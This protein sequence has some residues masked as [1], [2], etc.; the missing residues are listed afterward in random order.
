MSVAPYA[1]AA[2]KNETLY[3]VA[4]G[5]HTEIGLSRAAAR[6]LPPALAE[7][8][9]DARYLVFG[10]GARGYYTAGH[11]D[12]GDA[13]RAMAPGPAVLLVIPLAVPPA[14]E[15][16]ADSVLALPVSREGIAR[17]SE[18]LWDD[19]AKDS[20]GAPRRL[21]AGPK[22][23]SAFYASTGTYDIA[24]TCNTWT[25]E[26]LH[27]AGLPIDAEGVIF[28]GQVLSQAR[29]LALDAASPSTSRN[30]VARYFAPAAR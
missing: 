10:W 5:W 9:P 16:G 18:Y 24:R 22:P 28:A 20:D 11:P 15:F 23:G 17:L 25:A 13:L 2:P 4:G 14:Q 21:A 1:G 27:V 29:P 12:S 8:F 7:S 30:R 19:V 6:D 26:G 3:L